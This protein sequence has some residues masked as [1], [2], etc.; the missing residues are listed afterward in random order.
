MPAQFNRYIYSI[1]NRKPNNN[2]YSN[3]WK[4]TRLL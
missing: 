1:S 3:K 2:V 4:N